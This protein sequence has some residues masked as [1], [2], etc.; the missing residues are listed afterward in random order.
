MSLDEIQYYFI[1]C[2][3]SVARTGDI[4]AFRVHR[5]AKASY[6][7]NSNQVCSDRGNNNKGFKS[8]SKNLHIRIQNCTQTCIP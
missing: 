6:P 7:R 1:I 4:A 3:I 8:I 2:S 5:Q